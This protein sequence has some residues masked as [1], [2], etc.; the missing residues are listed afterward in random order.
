MGALIRDPRFVATTFI[1]LDF[2]STTPAGQ[3][4]E[5]IEVAAVGLRRADSSWQRTAT[6]SSLIRPPS[7]APITLSDVQQTGI[8]RAMVADASPAG[9][10]L[11]RL[12]ARLTAGP[13]LLVAHN[14]PTEA[15]CLHAYREACP[16]LSRT[17]LLCTVRLA[18]HLLPGFSYG[19][20]LDALINHFALPRPH[21]RHRAMPDVEATVELFQ[22]LVELADE[23]GAP[24]SLDA[25]MHHAGY[26]AKATRPVQE[27]IF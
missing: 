20:G 27:P 24:G 3:P 2:E 13:Y 4:P 1:V 18:R 10:V 5:P 6:F 7:H 9:D 11:A 22:R 19:Y 12:D 8:T 17:H 21:Q 25:L 23:A 15:G 26:V 16:T 14:A